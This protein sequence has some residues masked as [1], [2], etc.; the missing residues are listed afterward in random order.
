MYKRAERGWL[1]H[2]DFIALDLIC[3]LL[4]F[5]AAYFIRHGR[6]WT[7]NNTVYMALSITLLLLDLV[8]MAMLNT[9]HNVLKRD[10]FDELIQTLKQV[11]IVLGGMTIY[12]F[13]LRIGDVYSRATVFLTAGF[14]LVLGYGVRLLWKKH[15][16]KNNRH[17]K[18]RVMLLVSDSAQAEEVIRRVQAHPTDR[19][20]LAGV[21]LADRDAEGETLP[22]GTRIV[23]NLDS[24]AQYICREWVDE[25][26]F[27][28][29]V[30]SNMPLSLIEQC[31]EMAV[32]VHILLPS[33]RE[34]GNKQ[35]VEKLAGYQVL[36]GS[37]NYGTPA[38]LFL[39]RCVDVLGGLVGSLLALIIIAIVGPKIKKES[40]GPI[41]YRQERVGQNGRRFRI[42]KIRSMYLDADARK[43]ELMAQNRVSDGMMFKLDW[44]PRIIGNEILP[45]GTKK[46]GIGEMI[47]RTSLDEFP[48][49]FNVLMGDMSLVGTRPPTVD[50]WEK[51]QLHHRARLAMKPGITGMWQVSGRS[52]ITDFEE[53]VKLDTQYI[54]NWSLGL[55]LRILL[56]T[57]KAVLG[58]QGAM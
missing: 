50:E 30:Q 20:R 21:V 4:S 56:K 23:A 38:Q 33:Q 13:A 9:M 46:T 39:K 48:Q 44:D 12:M 43:Q 58:R 8:V 14:H 6:L 16:M 42:I 11:S 34:L 5:L 17:V 55:D 18:Q 3:L 35:F 7:L 57:V 26:L 10:P 27:A 29:G 31:R 32:T 1:K 45:D 22:D 37:V 36:T 49:F 47:R 40:P 15:L 41:L 19:V 52:E 2:I 24:A 53:V 54:L 28:P 51:Y 25:I